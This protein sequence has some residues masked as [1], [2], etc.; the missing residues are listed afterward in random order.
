MYMVIGWKKQI[1]R[2]P[3]HWKICSRNPLQDEEF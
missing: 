1:E 3:I 2:H